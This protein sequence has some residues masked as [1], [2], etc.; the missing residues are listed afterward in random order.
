MPEKSLSSF[1]AMLQRARTEMILTARIFPNTQQ[2][3]QTFDVAEIE[4]LSRHIEKFGQISP[5]LVRPDTARDGY[6]LIAG[7]RRLRALHVA[8]FEQALCRILE[9]DVPADLLESLNLGENLHRVGLSPREAAR[10]LAKMKQQRNCSFTELA[11]SECLDL[12]YV[13][14]TISLLKL[15]P[16]LL[17][18]VDVWLAVSVAYELAR[19]QSQTAM[20]ELAEAYKTGALGRDGIAR[21]VRDKLQKPKSTRAKKIS[22]PLAGGAL[23]LPTETTPATLE[24]ALT[25]L[26]KTVRKS[27]ANNESL[28][29]LVAKLKEATS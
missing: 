18:A 12:P 25:E 29:T 14:K 17:D 13:S 4:R 21:A 5:L 11:E 3:R 22:L 27:T 6:V 26:L 16:D 19:L 8:G 15:P 28:P 2:F 7:E 24:Q 10:A 20:R 23:S 9:K 1:G